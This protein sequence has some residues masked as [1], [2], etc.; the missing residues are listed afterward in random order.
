MI[1]I[2]ELEPT[3]ACLSL[4]ILIYDIKNLTTRKYAVN[5]DANIVAYVPWDGH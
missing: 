5:V 1:D 4:I 2:A 3:I